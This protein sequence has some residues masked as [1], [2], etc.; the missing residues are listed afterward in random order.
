MNEVANFCNGACRIRDKD[1]MSVKDSIFYSPTGRSLE[2]KTIPVDI[3]HYNGVMQLDSHS[4]YG[5][6]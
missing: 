3:T 6:Q 4:Y 5:T 1:S 2:Y